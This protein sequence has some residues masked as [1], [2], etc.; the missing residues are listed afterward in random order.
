MSEIDGPVCWLCARPLGAKIEWHHPVPKSRG[1]RE[2]VPVHP[3][4]HRTLHATFANAEL[5]RHGADVSGLR[6]EP[7][8]ARFLAWIGDKHPDF[9]ARTARRR[10]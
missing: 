2:T 8:V 6:A 3:I 5:A 7:A 1:G 4:C 10:R 9:H